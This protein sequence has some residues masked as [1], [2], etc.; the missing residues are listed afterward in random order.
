MKKI[1]YIEIDTHAE[2]AHAFMEIME[3]L[4]SFSVDYYFSEKIK[5]QVDD[6]N[7]QVFLSGSSM[8]LDQLKEK[9]YDLV[10]IG[11]V[12]RYFNIFDVIAAKYHTAVIV[13][14]MN[15]TGASQME[16]IKSI[17][18]KDRIYRLKL[19]GKEGLLRSP[20]VY[21]KAKHKLVL[22][23]QL[24]SDGFRFLPLFYTR[25][26]D[27]PD[28]KVFTIVI[29]GGVS[30]KRRDYKKVISTIKTIEELIKDSVID[31][32]LL[33][34]VFLGKAKNKELKNIIDLER[35]LQHINIM[36]F[37]ER[38]S[39]SAFNEWMRKAD[40]LWCPIQQ[41]TE[42]FSQREIYGKT[43][44][45]GNLGDAIKFGKWAVFPQSYP[46]KLDFIIPEEEDVI[47][48]FDRLKDT[49]YDFQKDYSKPM[50][51]RKLEKILNEMITSN[52]AV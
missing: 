37:S 45:T 41:E 28:N 9:N 36:Y 49:P 22:D 50:V 47:N 20:E 32:K 44:M 24:S 25:Q 17:F 34:F 29:P 4:R 30:Q 5:N 3:G 46:S 8:I 52:N 33:E 26:A 10:I 18:K 27:Q 21:R 42:F 23:E 51:Q 12:H 11:T 48:Q 2:I 19:L 1:A 40:V 13:H 6:H 14:N 38:V 31:K 16:L 43:K 35:S 39:P 15:F 7:V